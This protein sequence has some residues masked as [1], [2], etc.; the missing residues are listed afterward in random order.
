M[1]RAPLMAKVLGVL[2]LGG[3]LDAL[4]GKGIAFDEL[5]APFTKTGDDLRLK[6][7]R[8]YG[9][10]LGFTAKGWVDLETDELDIKGTVVPAYTFN[11]LLGYI[12]L[13]GGLLVGEKEVSTNPLAT[14]TPGFLR[15][16]FSIFDS[17][18]KKPP[19]G[20]EKSPTAPSKTY[21]PIPRPSE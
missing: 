12:P 10:A 3:V 19:P 2:S 4:S 8:A 13:L 9:G 20:E 1:V 6:N 7:A 17:P 18:S 5:E 21:E 14:L 16:L 11:K 15:G